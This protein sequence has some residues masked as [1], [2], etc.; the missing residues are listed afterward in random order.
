MNYRYPVL[1]AGAK[2]RKT[3][4]TKTHASGFVSTF[5]WSRKWCESI[6]ELVRAKPKKTRIA[7]DAQL[8]WLYHPANQPKFDF[9]CGLESWAAPNSD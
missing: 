6:T 8:K 1:E 5:D 3:R 7:F 9:I 4:E 2:R